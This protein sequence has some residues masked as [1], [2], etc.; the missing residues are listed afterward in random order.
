MVSGMSFTNGGRKQGNPVNSVIEVAFM[1]FSIETCPNIIALT[2]TS[3]CPAEHVRRLPSLV[4]SSNTSAPLDK[5]VE[6]LFHGS[7]T[8]FLALTRFTADSSRFSQ[9]TCS[10]RNNHKRTTAEVEI[11]KD[12]DPLN[13]VYGKNRVSG[14]ARSAEIPPFEEFPPLSTVYDEGSETPARIQAR[15][16]EWQYRLDRNIEPLRKENPEVILAVYLLARD[17]QDM[18]EH[19]RPQ[20]ELLTKAALGFLRSGSKPAGLANIVSALRRYCAE[21]EQRTDTNLRACLAPMLC[22]KGVLKKLWYRDDYIELMTGPESASSM[23]ALLQVA[24]LDSL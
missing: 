9:L 19:Y 24:L 20:Y 7:L 13:I 1:I 15:L 22:N 14:P 12:E 18:D 8:Y 23:A 21:E 3:G 11:D 10:S 5:T 16:V 2:I 17:Y 6:Y 4:G